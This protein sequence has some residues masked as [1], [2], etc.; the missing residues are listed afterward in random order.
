M[1]GNAY[2]RAAT[3]ATEALSGIRTVTAF[4]R[5]RLE[6]EK[7]TGNLAAAEAA[8]RKKGLGMGLGMV[9]GFKL[10]LASRTTGLICGLITLL[11]VEST[12]AFAQLLDRVCCME[13]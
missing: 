6:I 4:G 9:S 8:G 10:L 5:Q 2:S 3:V 13:E 1:V 12:Y 11:G 7:Y